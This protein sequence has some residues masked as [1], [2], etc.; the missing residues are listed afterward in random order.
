ME[1][2]IKKIDQVVNDI[3]S[4]FD[5]RNN[6]K[7]DLDEIRQFFLTEAIITKREGEKVVVMTVDEFITP[8]K[9]LLL[10]GTLT[11]FYEYETDC[12]TKVEN[13][14]AS[15]MSKYSKQG[16]MHGMDYRG[17]GKKHFQL[18][19]ES[20]HWKVASIVWEDEL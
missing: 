17:S 7:P 10:D 8:R 13:G 12:V 5:N 14:I 6:R 4:I 3:F 2:D 9:R 1:L 18:V 16:F 20:G 19:L 11:N 15:R